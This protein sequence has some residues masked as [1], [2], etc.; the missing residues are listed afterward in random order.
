M[1]GKAI[2]RADHD[3]DQPVR[4]R[5]EHARGEYPHHHRPVHADQRE[6]LVRAKD[7]GVGLKQLRADEHR[8]QP[9]HE[10]EGPDADHVLL[11][12]HLVVGGKAEVAQQPV[13]VGLAL[14]E[15]RLAAE[16]PLD[17]VHGEAEADQKADHAEQVAEHD[18]D[19]VF[20]RLL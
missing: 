1:R 11:R 19:V 13:F 10:E 9:A 17:R 4:E 16:Q 8:V 12:D 15:R 6:V 2:R 3:R 7:M 14:G 5:P 20:A 18:R